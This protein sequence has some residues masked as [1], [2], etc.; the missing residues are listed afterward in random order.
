MIT[1]DPDSLRAKL[2]E[3]EDAMGKPSFWDDQQQAAKT[4]AEHARLS[5]RLER[6]DRQQ[7]WA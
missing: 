2:G 3:L 4:S 1:F 6:Y 7:K 5:R